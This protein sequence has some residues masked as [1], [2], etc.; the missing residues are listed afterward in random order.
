MASTDSNAAAVLVASGILGF[1]GFLK[2]SSVS[3]ALLSLRDDP[4]SLGYGSVHPAFSFVHERDDVWRFIDN[5]FRFDDAESLQQFCALKG[6]TACLPFLFKRVVENSPASQKCVQFL[7]KRGATPLCTEVQYDRIPSL[8]DAHF[9]AMITHGMMPPNS[10]FSRA[11]VQGQGELYVPMLSALIEADKFGAAERLLEKGANADVCSWYTR[12]PP[13]PQTSSRLTPLRILISRLARVRDPEDPVSV[14]KRREGL[15]LLRRLVCVCKKAG[16]LLWR[17]RPGVQGGWGEGI[18]IIHQDLTPLVLACMYRDA[19]AVGVLT[20]VQDVNVALVKA[21]SRAL[22]ILFHVLGPTCRNG[23]STDTVDSLSAATIGRLT[24]WGGVDV[25]AVDTNGHTA[26]SLACSLGMPKSA[27]AL[28]KGGSTLGMVKWGKRMSESPVLKSLEADGD[29]QTRV[30]LFSLLLEWAVSKDSDREGLLRLFA[31]ECP[32][33]LVMMTTAKARREAEAIT[34]L[35]VLAQRGYDLKVLMADGHTALSLACDLRL[36]SSFIEFLFDKGLSAGGVGEGRVH[37]P[38]VEACDNFSNLRIVSLLLQKGADPNR[39]GLRQGVL[40]SPLQAALDQDPTRL[41]GGSPLLE[42]VV[43]VVRVLIDAGARCPRAPPPLSQTASVTRSSE[44]LGA[45]PL[46]YSHLSPVMK[47]CEMRDACL[48][49]FLCKKGGAVPIGEKE[50]AEVVT[51]YLSDRTNDSETRGEE[52]EEMQRVR[53]LNQWRQAEALLQG[54]TLTD[55]SALLL[56]HWP[57]HS[58]TSRRPTRFGCGSWLIDLICLEEARGPVLLKIIECVPSHEILYESI[59][60][61]E[62]EKMIPIGWKDG[63]QALIKR[64]LPALATAFSQ[65]LLSAFHH[66]MTGAPLRFEKTRG[67]R[68]SKNELVQE[69][70]AAAW[71]L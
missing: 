50:L 22:S 63:V 62:A 40:T 28:M 10:W 9:E 55:V 67:D 3:K 64:A 57:P 5:C 44:N 66:I 68:K 52:G 53:L 16:C 7:S 54:Q 27:E 33:R 71:Q 59:K 65:Q 18:G 49:G 13:T 14:L 17:A 20:E 61:S 42:A 8:T 19:E 45:P 26:L 35:N 15:S 32:I 6:G 1:L 37:L 11:D 12:F 60:D 4:S 69:V 51:V 70:V 41:Q 58:A 47:V 29:S 31:R 25:N 39:L 36:T 23:V 38:L 56:T 48:L 34:L 46:R 2:L 43:S 24:N 30:T 21:P